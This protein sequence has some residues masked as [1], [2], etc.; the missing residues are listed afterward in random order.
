VRKG[1]ET[2]KEQL[3]NHL[4]RPLAISG[5]EQDAIE[6]LFFDLVRTTAAALPE[7]ECCL[8]VLNLVSST[9]PSEALFHGSNLARCAHSERMISVHCQK[10]VAFFLITL[11]L[12]K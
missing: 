9:L 6:V 10:H 2:S 1:V 3:A 12:G 4:K 5:H 8:L 7:R 11:R